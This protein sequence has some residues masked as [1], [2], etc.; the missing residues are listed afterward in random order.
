MAEYLGLTAP[1]ADG[2]G[3]A[4]FIG[5]RNQLHPGEEP[6]KGESGDQ[7]IALHE[8]AERLSVPRPRKSMRR[9]FAL[10]DWSARSWRTVTKAED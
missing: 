10:I 1:A 2:F 3:E 4:P 8:L 7:A 6:L 9:I 5:F